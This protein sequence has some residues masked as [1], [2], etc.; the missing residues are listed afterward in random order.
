MDIPESRILKKLIGLTL[1][2]TAS[3]YVQAAERDTVSLRHQLLHEGHFSGHLRTFFMATDNAPGFTD[4]YAWAAGA[5]IRYE[6]ADF[7]GF[8]FGLT[9]FFI[10]NVLSSDLGYIDPRGGSASRYEIGLFDIANPG[11]REDLDRLEDLY[12]RYSR[13]GFLVEAGR[14]EINT[15]FINRQDGRMRG[16]IEEGLRTIWGASDKLKLE[17][18]WIRRISPRST[19]RW[20]RMADSYGVYPSGVNEWGT[21]SAYAGNTSSAGTAIAGITWRP[22][23]ALELQGWNQWAENVFNTGLLKAE[24]KPGSG[25]RGRGMLGLQYI[26]QDALNNGGH[27]D[28]LK[29]YI[30]KGSVAQVISARAGLQHRHWEGYLN[31]TRILSGGRYLMPRE[32]GREPF[33]TFMPRERNEGLADVHAVT[34]SLGTQFVEKKLKPSITYGHFYLPRPEDAADNKYG[35]PSYRQ[36]NIEVH[37]SFDGYL[38]GLQLY[39]LMAAKGRLG[40]KVIA[41]RYVFNK[42]GMVN[43]NLQVDYTF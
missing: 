13:R 22:S 12:L 42:T 4:Y 31:Y 6:S 15:P 2:L 35:L 11:N 18:Y 5:G 43:W 9:G 19:V 7:K 33:Y 24:W 17:A 16:T 34:L 29:A 3:L 37:Y 27:P 25:L 26:R 36:L 23:G 38:K 10:Y 28:S 32:W 39:F 40:D 41:D 14:F 30:R 1:L 20:Y 21:K 8:R